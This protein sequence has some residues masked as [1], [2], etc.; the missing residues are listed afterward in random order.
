MLFPC[1]CRGPV[2]RRQEMYF[3]FFMCRFF[4]RAHEICMSSTGKDLVQGIRLYSVH[5]YPPAKNV[6]VCVCVLVSHRRA[7]GGGA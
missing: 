6:Y 3:T 4:L 2:T 5:R 1:P 7:V